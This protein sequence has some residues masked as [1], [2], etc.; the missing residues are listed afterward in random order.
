MQILRDVKITAANKR[1]KCYPLVYQ[2][3]RAILNNYIKM[4]PPELLQDKLI[5]LVSL[6]VYHTWYV[7]WLL[8]LLKQIQAVNLRFWEVLAPH[9][10]ARAREAAYFEDSG[11]ILW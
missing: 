3:V 8:V 6:P 11:R 9:A 4:Q 10:Q 2:G 7:S 1:V 5:R